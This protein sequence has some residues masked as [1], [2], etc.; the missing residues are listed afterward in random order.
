[1]HRKRNKRDW[2]EKGI[3]R[4][5]ERKNEKW[6][7]SDTKKEEVKMDICEYTALDSQS[8][9]AVALILKANWLH[10]EEIKNSKISGIYFIFDKSSNG[11]VYIGKSVNIAGRLANHP[12]YLPKQDYVMIFPVLDKKFLYK[13]ESLFIKIFKPQEN[14]SGR[15]A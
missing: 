13:L 6:G 5:F 9:E 1:L 14:I 11:I 8:A 2:K 4:Q 3:G 12:V 15:T 7:V 10:F